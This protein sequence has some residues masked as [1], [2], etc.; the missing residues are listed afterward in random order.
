MIYKCPTCSAALIYDPESGK[1][2]CDNCNNTYETYELQNKTTTVP[3]Q[4]T[5]PDINIQTL[6]STPKWETSYAS[7]EDSMECRIYT[8]SSCAAEIAV[9][10]EEVSTF[11]A[12]CGQPTVIFSR[13]AT[14]I[15]PKYIIPFTVTKER[16]I[17]LIQDT[18]TKKGEFVPDDLANLKPDRVIGIYIPYYLYDIHYYDRQLLQ[19]KIKHETYGSRYKH[20]SIQS[21]NTPQIRYY[22]REAECDFTNIA[23]DA[24][25]Q[26]NNT[27]SQRL[28]PYYTL[29]MVPFSP[30]YLSGFYTD[31]RD[32][33]PN[34]LDALAT[35][36]AMKLFNDSITQSIFAKEV[37]AIKSDPKIEIKKREY[38]LFP[39]W[40]V[41]FRYENIP[42]TILVNGQT[43][44]IL[45][46]VPID[47]KRAK[48]FF[49]L[50]G[51]VITLFLIPCM[52]FLISPE[53]LDID[54]FSLSVGIFAVAGSFYL[55][56]RKSLKK[57]KKNIQLSSSNTL[58]RYVDHRQDRK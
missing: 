5:K 17:S 3:L 51:T 4:E 21:T 56:G 24:S 52:H 45:G 48:T 50:V 2:K 32:V 6:S 12:Y 30:E 8:C 27:I 39:A 26:L 40:F 36:R 33:D 46:S 28:E 31:F 15:R 18:F 14:T 9:S 19:G 13:I 43:E 37:S 38:A 57:L 20:M 1:M 29:K 35:L 54:S 58:T 23:V 49:L 53:Y 47:K 42:Y 34:Q 41:T 7:S 44:K 10:E 22:E 55:G 16:A 11:C 25:I